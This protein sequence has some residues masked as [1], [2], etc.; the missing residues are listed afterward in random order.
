M[1][2]V[3][4]AY[5][6][7]MPDVESLKR[8]RDRFVALAFC[9]ADV[10]LEVNRDL[11]I[12]YAGGATVALIGT[13]AEACIGQSFLDIIVRDDRPLLSELIANMTAASRLEP[14]PVHLDGPAGPTTTLLLTG[15]LLPELP[16]SRFFALRL[17]SV[18][19]GCADL[20]QSPRDPRS[21]LYGLD[22]FTSEAGRCLKTMAGQAGDPQLTVI[23]MQGLAA[24][25]SA[26]PPAS[27]EPLLE[28]I[29]ACLRVAGAPHDIAGRLDGENFGLLQRAGKTVDDLTT[30][31]TQHLSVADSG[32]FEVEVTA[33]TM[34]TVPCD[35]SEADLVNALRFSLE[36]F[37]AAEDPQ[38]GMADLSLN[39]QQQVD[40]AS[41]KISDFREMV[42]AADFDVAFQPIVKLA[43]RDITHFE[44][45]C[46]FGG[47][48]D[49]SPYE[50]ITFA[51]NTGLI[52]DFDYAMCRKL[53]GWLEQVKRNGQP[54]KVA[55]NLSGRSVGNTSFL[56][57]LQQLLKEHDGLRS[58]LIIEIT[59]SARI[60]DLAKA[61][62]F[63][64]SLRKAGHKVCLDDFGAGASALRYL[65]ELEVDIVKIDGHYVRG[66]VSD[67]KLRAFL[68]AI[69]GLC[70]ELGITTVAEM[71][72]D[73]ATVDILQ[74]CGIELG[75]GFLFGKPS[76]EIAGLSVPGPGEAA[77]DRQAGFWHRRAEA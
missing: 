23:R 50:L 36:Q 4:R 35:V 65:H 17:G 46:R 37:C 2:T 76:F 21:K 34:L 22:A 31:L 70:R 8:E 1:S 57:A 54:C 53:L 7:G 9:A 26:I 13:E 44:A 68:R 39:L 66:A 55:M 25:L 28:T 27:A 14:V 20:G 43:T 47:G 49:R 59:E 16:E 71:V 52:C 41:R 69:A 15:Y 24:C 62:R 60:G 19:D 40:A 11:E 75:Q 30:R 56:V 33:A 3:A 58:Q 32:G 63:I 74:A 18:N 12:V 77:A 72:E 64:Q 61:N 38:T 29:G 48:S 42:S 6:A 45:L 51:E 73:E 67:R 10:L 5:D